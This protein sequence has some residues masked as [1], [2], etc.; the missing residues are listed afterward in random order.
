MDHFHHKDGQLWCEGVPLADIAKRF[1]T[2]AYVYSVATV[3]GHIEGLRRA[4]DGLDPMIC[5][6]VKANSNLALLSVIKDTGCGFDIVSGGELDRLKRI[7]ADPKKVVFSGV[8]KTVDEM[9]AAL[10]FGVHSYNVE[11][12]AE[13]ELL[14]HVAAEH[15]TRAAVSLRVNPDVDPKTHRYITT[16]KRETKFGVDLDRGEVLAH[17]VLASDALE[18]IGIQC[19]IGSQIT[20]VEPYAAAVARTVA[21]ATKL[22]AVAPSLQWLDMGGGYGIYYRDTN[23][24]DLVDYAD[25]VRPVLEGANLELIM[26]PGRVIVGNAGVMLT[27]VLFNKHGGER[28]FVIV[29]AGMNDLLR[30]SLYGGF[31]RIWPISGDAPPA[32]GTEP[33]LPLA[34]IVGPVCESGDFLAEDRP[35]P[36]VAAGDVLAVMSVGAYAFSMASNY[37]ART[38][39]PEILIDG[40]RV[41]LARR[42]ETYDDLVRGEDATP[43]FDPLNESVA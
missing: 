24:P 6:A 31:H 9:R 42:R 5:Y 22:Q 12:E 8:G 37:N 32:L 20:S 27:E 23:V 26:E 10:D 7:G 28:R 17:R 40:D 41:A 15:G 2:P 34:D 35:L 29:D 13:L 18:L 3:R 39:P 19:H 36:S 30:P 14:A 1:G 43:S 4:F 25:A 16:G 21:L 38:R 33:D 11:S